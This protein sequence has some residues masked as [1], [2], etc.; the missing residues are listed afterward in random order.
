MDFFQN[1]VV[2]L[3][4]ATGGLGGCLLYKLAVV[5]RVPKI[6]VVI[7]KT[8]E[9][10][11]QTWSTIMPNHVDEVLRTGSIKFVFGDLTA[12]QFG[13]AEHNVR[14]LEKD[15]TIV[16][17]A[18]ANISLRLPLRQAVQDNCLSALDLGEMATRFTKLVCFVQVSSAYALSDLPDG[19][20]E[21]RLYPIGDSDQLLNDILSDK[22]DGPGEFAWPY[23]RSKRL[24]ECLLDRRL[25]QKLPLVIVRPTGI[26]PA[27]HEPFE[28]YLPNASCPLNTFYARM[29]YPTGGSAVFHAPVGFSSGKNIVDEI[30]VDLASNIIL[31]H[32][33]RGTRGVIHTSS[34]SYI[35]RTFDDYLQDLARYV[36]DDWRTKMARPVFTTDRTARQCPVAEFYV[37]K[38]RNWLVKAD[39]SRNLDMSGPIGLDIGDHDLQAF[40]EKRV[41]RIFA[42]T[43]KFLETKEKRAMSQQLKTK[44]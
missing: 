15:V 29:M 31:Q 27:I 44:L 6:Y 13:I 42:E 33:R 3:T 41:R 22:M 12:P 28:L 8:P 1:Q 2:L 10:A 4:G 30:P 9:K 19:P 5:L 16:I 35:P 7:R 34:Q 18:A 25:G 37:I 20:M 24:M 43:K 21:E 17:N 11:I 26:A 23:A 32:V 39:R 40:T 38:S 36:P 14:A